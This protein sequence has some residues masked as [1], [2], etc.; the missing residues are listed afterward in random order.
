[1]VFS[2]RAG[3]QEPQENSD[4]GQRR[5]QEYLSCAEPHHEV[6]DEGVLSLSRAVAHHH[7]PAVRLSQFAAG[8]RG[9]LI[10]PGGTSS[11]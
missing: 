5:A 11:G 6:S 3:G 7:P 10:R 1:M 4:T 2:S 9:H 8:W